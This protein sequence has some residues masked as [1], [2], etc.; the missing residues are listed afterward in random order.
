[1]LNKKIVYQDLKNVLDND[2]MQ[3][4]IYLNPFI[5]KL[6]YGATIVA[7]AACLTAILINIFMFGSMKSGGAFPGLFISLIILYLLHTQRTL[8][9]LH[10][11]LWSLALVPIIWG[12]ATFGI[13]APG[14]MFAP[15]AIVAAS[16]LLSIRQTLLM[17]FTIIFVTLVQYQLILQGTYEVRSPLNFIKLM[18][19]IF[20]LLTA[21]LMGMVGVKALNN[22]FSRVRQL[23]NSLKEKAEELSQSEAS[24]SSLFLSNP[25][26]SFSFDLEGRLIEVNHAFMNN[27]GYSRE[28]LISKK[29]EDVGFFFEDSTHQNT[30]KQS[31]QNIHRLESQEHAVQFHF[32]D[33]SIRHYLLNTSTF[34]L[35]GGKRIVATLIDQTDRL[36]AEKAQNLLQVELESRVEARTKELTQ[37]LETL[38]QT[39]NELMQVEKM[40]SL[41]A[42]VAGV[43]HE[44]NTPIGN[45]LMVASTLSDVHREF[46]DSSSKGFSRS[47]F[48]HYLE[49]VEE[50]AKILNRTLSRTANLIVSFKQ[51]AV[52]RTSEQ[53]RSFE[54]Q[55]IV[56]EI[57]ITI[58]PSLKKTPH[59][60]ITNVPVGIVFDSYP[61]SLGQVFINLITNALMHAFD[62]SEMSP[63]VGEIKMFVE[64]ENEWVKIIFS[65]NGKGIK[66]EDKSKVFDPFFTTKLGQGGS[67]LGLSIVYNIVTG[68]LG[69]TIE[70]ESE[71]GKGAKFII[72][73]PLVAPS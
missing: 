47:S 64:M 23:V 30:T 68:I 26:P 28:Q 59:Q 67:G 71:V 61:G 2:E 60:L 56:D 22:E 31:V 72:N 53:R 8:T 39:Q 65:D 42:M 46:V 6:I 44:L 29:I 40:A 51:I 70:L 36:M 55:E 38:K 43:A 11:L 37:T 16:W 57:V 3:R 32:A 73:L 54:L 66:N 20:I 63:S 49:S 15:I 35:V 27:F 34:S 7:F 58:S 13:N 21:F 4:Q 12:M 69:G 48:N 52:D 45:A 17:M 1:M 41:G 19:L 50:S 18:S 14:L 24:F 9:A 10:I 33:G 5:I 25:L 62:E